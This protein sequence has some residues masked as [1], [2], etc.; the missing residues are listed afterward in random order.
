MDQTRTS[1]TQ[2]TRCWI[3][4]ATPSTTFSSTRVLSCALSSL[5]AST[6]FGSTVWTQMNFSWELAI[7]LTW[8]NARRSSKR[9]LHLKQE[10]YLTLCCSLCRHNAWCNW[11]KTKERVLLECSPRAVEKPLF[12]WSARFAGH[13]L[14][15]T[16]WLLSSPSLLSSERMLTM[17]SSQKMCNGSLKQCTRMESLITSNHATRW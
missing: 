4:I 17:L 12:W 8:S 2:R 9:Q 13:S 15:P 5:S 3:T 16:M 11:L 1:I 10:T 7:W 6:Q 14:T